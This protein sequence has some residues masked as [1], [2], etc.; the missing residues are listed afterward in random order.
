MR[1][2][3]SLQGRDIYIYIYI[4]IYIFFK[5]ESM[6]D[7]SLYFFFFPKVC[8]CFFGL[9]FNFLSDLESPKRFFFFKKKIYLFLFHHKWLIWGFLYPGVL[10]D[11][12]SRLKEEP[13]PCSFMSYLE[14]CDYNFFEM[15]LI[16]FFI[17]LV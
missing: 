1:E 11:R 3:K 8:Y 13:P 14:K 17:F 2:L 15:Q 16:I 10:G 12:L 7:K 5:K 9:T 4:Y 6:E